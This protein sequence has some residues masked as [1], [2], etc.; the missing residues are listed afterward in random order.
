MSGVARSGLRPEIVAA[1]LMGIGVAGFVGAWLVHKQQTASF[2]E[3]PEASGEVGFVAVYVQQP[4]GPVRLQ[5]SR[6]R[7]VKRP[8]SVAFQLTTTGAGPRSVRIELESE[9][10]RTVLHEQK[11]D[12]PADQAMIDYVLELG[13][14]VPD[15]LKVIV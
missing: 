12:A 6:V 11:L 9:G 5:P 4:H 3:R 2:A 1:I 15:D 7:V 13:D 8:Q 14:D 10:K